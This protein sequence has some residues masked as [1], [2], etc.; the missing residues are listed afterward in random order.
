M[1]RKPTNEQLQQQLDKVIATLRREII[2]GRYEVGKF[3]PSEALL[4]KR[5]KLSNKSLRRGLDTLV[6]EGWITKVPRVGNRVNIRRE[7]VT[8]QLVCSFTIWRDLALTGLLDD[9]HRQHPWITVVPK[10]FPRASLRGEDFGYID[11][12]DVIVINESQ[13]SEI[14]GQRQ[15]L[16]LEPVP[17]RRETYPFL[18]DLFMVE[19]LL[20][21]QPLVFSPIVLCYN[22]AHFREC[23]L[24]EP[25]GSWTW[26]DLMT[27]AQQLSNGSGRFGFCFHLPS[28]NRWTNFLL[29]SGERFEWNGDQLRDIRGTRLLDSI[30]LCKE[31]VH[32]RSFFPLYLAESSDE[33]NE[34]FLEGKLSMVLNSYTNLNDFRQSDLDYDVSP[35]PFI[36]E[37]RAL[38][39]ALGA[40]V[41]RFSTHKA[42]ALLLVDYLA[43]RRGQE[44]IHRHTTS[45][46]GDQFLA[47]VPP[48]REFNSPSRW[49]MYRDMMFSYRW[50]HDLNLSVQSLPQLTRL[51][52]AYWANMLTEDELCDRIKMTLSTT[53]SMS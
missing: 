32:N 1:K 30:R 53:S 50:K 7:P 26:N 10:A 45:I 39:F 42:E 8:L 52:K 28:D 22:K 48:Q 13:F 12:G 24:P 51:L 25:T 33:I 44:Y 23:G 35:S 11:N 19:D 6:E 36:T 47:A 38:A 9:F 3:L 41:N 34:M 40:A 17:V 5:F 18:T 20:Y 49:S 43:S 2:E 16:S 14:V 15:H 46:P 31:I 21:V 37:P 29:Q 4:S 27:Y